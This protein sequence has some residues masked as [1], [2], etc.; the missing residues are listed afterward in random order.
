MSSGDL[1]IQAAAAQQAIDRGGGDGHDWMLVAL[2]RSAADD[3]A[4]ADAAFATARAL[5]PQNPAILT[6]MAI[7]LRRQGRIRD[8]VLACDAAIQVWPDYADAWLERGS[9]LTMGNSPLAHASF[10]R[11][12]ELDPGNPAAHAALAAIAAR[13]GQADEARKQ[14]DRALALQP[15]HPLAICALA[16]VATDTGNPQ[17]A[18]AML[19]DLLPRLTEASSD[20]SLA[21][22]ML[23]NACHKLGDASHAYD[24]WVRSKADFYELN[25]R[26]LK[27]RLTHRQF[28]EAVT[29]ALLAVP[30][31]TWANVHKAEQRTTDV[32][33]HIFV[34][35]YPRSGN[36]LLENIL[37]SLPGVFALEERPT[38]S[39][40][41]HTYLNGSAPE[42]VA[43]LSD[44]ANLDEQGL[45]RFRTDYWATVR[46]AGLPA[47]TTAFVD[48]DPLK[49]TRLPLI[50]RLF[51]DARVLLMRRDPRDV[52]FSCFRTN[53]AFSSG[54]LDFTTVERTARHYDA[55]MRLTELALERLPL[56]V[57]EVHYH[58]LVQNFDEET[59]AICAFAGLEW[60][61]D[62]HRFANTAQQRGVTTASV[63]Q[64]R[65]GLFDGTRQWEPYARYLDPVMPMLQPWIE[66]FGY[67]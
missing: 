55:M 25:E 42:I 53:F 20:R 62:V 57:R 64:V 26:S 32:A 52:V 8:A 37:A 49:G 7:H 30:E 31:T 34:L 65:Q 14:A 19:E 63:G 39:L 23:G 15:G 4:G 38:L 10:A 61:E 9:L 36:T 58:R 50:S 27:G 47:D 48:M 45:D 29:E 2:H 1:E 54:T 18:R 44:F 17:Q 5:E 67:A 21:L 43:G 41:D 6:G 13:L 28:V 66:K 56:K 59:K 33:R 35:G 46:G 22:G 60:S 40:A 11:A 24:A 16:S 51:P 12:A 3:V